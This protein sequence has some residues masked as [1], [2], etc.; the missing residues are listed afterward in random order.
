MDNLMFTAIWWM[1]GAGPWFYFYSRRHDLTVCS[2]FFF[3]VLGL[4]MGPLSFL[5]AFMI[6]GDH[7]PSKVVVKKWGK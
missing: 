1:L 3:S 2:L 5:F 4:F 6:F 7:S